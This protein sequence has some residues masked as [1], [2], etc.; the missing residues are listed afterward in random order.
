VRMMA[1]EPEV[2]GP[3]NLGNP[4]EISML[5]L[6]QTILRLT[7]SKSALM[8][9]PLPPDDPKQRQPDIRQARELLDWAPTVELEA[10]LTRTIAYFDE[11]L[12]SR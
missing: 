9:R 2:T 7:G 11:L 4:V 1:T 5:Q 3:V 8:R 12:A 6:A 10:G